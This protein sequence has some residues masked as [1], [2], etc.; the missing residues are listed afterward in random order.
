MK[1][2]RLEAP[3]ALA[4]IAGAFVVLVLLV[5]ALLS[6]RVER[7]ACL[8]DWFCCAR[9]QRAAG[10]T[11]A[12]VDLECALSCGFCRAEAAVNGQR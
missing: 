11:W 7:V 6:T 8:P 3:K 4:I 10:R 2:R 1:Q 5:L 9:A 12:D